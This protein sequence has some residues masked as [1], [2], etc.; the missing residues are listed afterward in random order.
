MRST[1]SSGVMIER[2]AGSERPL[3]DQQGA[4]R[5]VMPRSQFG[6]RHQEADIRPALGEVRHDRDDEIVLVDGVQHFG[7][8]HDLVVRQRGALLRRR[9]RG[10]R[11]RDLREAE[12]GARQLAE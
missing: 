12:P 2:M 1:Q 9:H 6:E 3:A 5:V 11:Q 4:A 10:R 8:L 7:R